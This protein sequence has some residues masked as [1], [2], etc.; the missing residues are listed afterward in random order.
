[1]K[2]SHIVNCILSLFLFSLF[3]Y[4]F[5]NSIDNYEITAFFN[6]D[7]MYL[8]SLYKDIFIDGFSFSGWRLQPAPAFFPDMPL[9]FFFMFI[10]GDLTI[11]A[12]LFAIIQPV[13]LLLSFFML[14]KLFFPE[15]IIQILSAICIIF[16]IIF[17]L[18]INFTSMFNLFVYMF[19]PNYHFSVFI[20]SIFSLILLINYLQTHKLKFLVLIFFITLLTA[21]SDLLFLEM[22]VMPSILTLFI[23][24][25]MKLVD[26]DDCSYFVLSVFSAGISSLM[27]YYVLKKVDMLSLIQFPY[28]NKIDIFERITVF[29]NEI[30]NNVSFMIM[31]ASLAI[32]II[33]TV[34]FFKKTFPDLNKSENIIPLYVYKIFS[35]IVA[36]SVVFFPAILLDREAMVTLRYS[37]FVP[38]I[39]FLNMAIYYLLYLKTGKFEKLQYMKTVIL[40]LLFI[41]ALFQLA[42]PV[43]HIGIAGYYPPITKFLD[44]NCEKFNLKFGLSNYSNAKLN[45]VFSKKG[46]KSYQVMISDHTVS[47]YCHINNQKWYI[48]EKSSKYPES[49]YN[50]ILSEG[51]SKNGI[52]KFLGTPTDIVDAPG[53]KLLVFNNPDFNKKVKNIFAIAYIGYLNSIKNAFPSYK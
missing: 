51:M 47:P 6:G 24:Y 34:L 40:C 29:V 3:L 1:M 2:K 52:I 30:K 8:P 19:I 33:F 10:T 4:L 23:L 18:S 15:A 36:L 31:L 16:V 26:I 42:S 13:L 21:S 45:T 22:Y 17:F 5:L 39:L 48:D 46:N 44:D 37:C 9:Y 35:S 20:M 11:S 28:D 27:F 53:M 38:I 25:Y 7:T 12:Y 41:F 43:D 50:F 14:L 32:I 49:Y